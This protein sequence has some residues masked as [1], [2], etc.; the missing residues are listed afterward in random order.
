[1]PF[2]IVCLWSFVICFLIIV[3]FVW[4]GNGVRMTGFLNLGSNF[5]AE[6]YLKISKLSLDLS[7]ENYNLLQP[8]FGIEPYFKYAVVSEV[9]TAI[10]CLK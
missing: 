9:H 1:M 2:K 4:S 3:G 8:R 5:C 10:V 7:H 6:F